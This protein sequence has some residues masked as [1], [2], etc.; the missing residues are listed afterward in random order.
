MCKID[1]ML[2]SYM[3]CKKDVMQVIINN[4]VGILNAS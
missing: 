1:I 3:L 4:V 2:D